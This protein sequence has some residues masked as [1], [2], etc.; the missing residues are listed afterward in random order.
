MTRIAYTAGWGFE[1]LERDCVDNSVPA[2]TSNTIKPTPAK[3]TETS[4]SHAKTPATIMNTPA[5]IARPPLAERLTYRPKADIANDRVER[6]GQGCRCG[7]QTRLA[8][9]P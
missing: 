4:P 2:P 1:T 9:F 6:S 3:V 5:A 8:V 7:G